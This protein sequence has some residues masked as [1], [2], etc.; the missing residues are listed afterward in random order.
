MRQEF[1]QSI[2]QRV[3]LA[4][5]AMQRH[6]WEQGVVAQAFLESGDVETAC[7]DPASLRRD[8][9]YVPSTGI[10]EGLRK[11]AQWFKEYEK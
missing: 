7:A 4:T 9:G 5:L 3:M 6:D 1:D 8:F 11:F 2:L 10:R